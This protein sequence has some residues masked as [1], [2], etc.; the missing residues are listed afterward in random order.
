MNSLQ[1]HFATGPIGM[2]LATIIAP[3]VSSSRCAPTGLKADAAPEEIELRVSICV[4]CRYPFSLQRQ[5]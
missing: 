3:L 2:S 4:L 1:Q 5:A